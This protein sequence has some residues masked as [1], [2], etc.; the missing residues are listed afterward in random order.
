MFYLEMCS[1]NV[2]LQS[3]IFFFLSMGRIKNDQMCYL[4]TEWYGK[5]WTESSVYALAYFP[6]TVSEAFK[7]KHSHKDKKWA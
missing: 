3:C 7:Y 4:R 2:S 5:Y 6:S 1:I